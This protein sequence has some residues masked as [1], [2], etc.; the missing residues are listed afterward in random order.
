MSNEVV[1][2]REIAPGVSINSSMTPQ[3]RFEII[4]AAGVA[5]KQ[6]HGDGNMRTFETGERDLKSQA[7]KSS[8]DGKE[9]KIRSHILKSLE[10]WANSQDVAWQVK[11]E[12][13]LQQWARLIMAGTHVAGANPQGGWNIYP[14][15]E[16][17]LGLAVDKAA[18]ATDKDGYAKASEIT[19]EL[20]HGYRL[21]GAATQTWH[22]AD[23]VAG[24]R[25]ARI[26]NLSQAQ[27]DAI[28][29]AKADTK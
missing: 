8:A 10:E 14:R 11:N 6:E 17:T 15:P 5:P 13:L 29:T 7:A 12:P 22:V 23:L 9:F 1:V 27:L 20:L 19:G 2:S 25:L 18:K 4:K 26:G 21:P 3:Q 16:Y 28:L 24:L